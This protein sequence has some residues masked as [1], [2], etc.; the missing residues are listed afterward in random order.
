MV[1]YLLIQAVLIAVVFHFVWTTFGRRL[2]RQL[3]HDP[4]LETL[5]ELD[6]V[7]ERLA[8]LPT[9]EEA[10]ASGLAH[11][12]LDLLRGESHRKERELE[13]RLERIRRDKKR[14]H[15]VS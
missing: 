12:A 1:A 11:E 4:E 8:A 15:A 9:P 7:R 14:A 5:R 6:D 13:A 3:S 2:A 10:E